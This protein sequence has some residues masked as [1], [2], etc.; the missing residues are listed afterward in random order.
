M[1]D[2]NKRPAELA[3][4]E[5]EQDGTLSPITVRIPSAVKLTGISRSRLYKLIRDK[6]IE[7]VKLGTSTLVLVDSLKSFIDTLRVRN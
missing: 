1:K 2:R 7:T 3:A 4:G 5:M 6:E